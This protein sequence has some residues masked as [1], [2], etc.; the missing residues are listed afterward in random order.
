MWPAS[1]MVVVVVLEFVARKLL[2]YYYYVL[3]LTLERA[4]MGPAFFGDCCWPL[5]TQAQRVGGVYYGVPFH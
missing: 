1:K 3:Q 2:Y 4:A 5:D